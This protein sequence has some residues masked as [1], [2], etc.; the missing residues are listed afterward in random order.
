MEFYCFELGPI[1]IPMIE[2]DDGQSLTTIKKASD[3]VGLE[4]INTRKLLSRYPERFSKLSVTNCHA[5]NFLSQNRREFEIGKVS[6]DVRL[7]NENDIL[8]LALMSNNWE[9][10]DK[11]KDFLHARAMRHYVH[12]DVFLKVCAERDEMAQR[13]LVAEERFA[14]SIIDIEDLKNRMLR[15]EGLI[16][17]LDKMVSCAG[18]Q[19]NQAKKLKL[20][21][22]SN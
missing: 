9:F 2:T 14:T 15:F 1:F 19:L 12:K 18:I 5:K 7:L 20:V 13:L 4:I 10:R 16:P 22:Q 21:K 11:F 6:G 17:N 3:A 8:E